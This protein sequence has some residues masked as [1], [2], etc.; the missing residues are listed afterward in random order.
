[1]LSRSVPHDPLKQHTG[2]LPPVLH[3]PRLL[4]RPA[5]PRSVRSEFTAEMATLAT[6]VPMLARL[7]DVLAT[8][9]RVPDY[10]EAP[11]DDRR[12]R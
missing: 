3:A 7:P 4:P 5:L 1:M 8:T 9:L 11:V 12:E 6:H 2:V 10:L